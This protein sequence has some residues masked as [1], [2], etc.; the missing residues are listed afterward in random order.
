MKP[1]PT[2]E[3][4]GLQPVIALAER[5]GQLFILLARIATALERRNED[6]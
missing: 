6:V 3:N 4:L 2:P 5:E 1:T